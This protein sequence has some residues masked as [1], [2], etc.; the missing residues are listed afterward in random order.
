MVYNKTELDEAFKDKRFDDGIRVEL[1]FDNTEDQYPDGRNI[2][3]WV[4]MYV[5]Q[6]EGGVMYESQAFLMI[7]GYVSLSMPC[8]ARS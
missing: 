2:E 8:N 5:I 3:G 7:V 6:I 1:I 4:C